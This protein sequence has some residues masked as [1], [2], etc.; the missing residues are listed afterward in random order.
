MT[1]GKIDIDGRSKLNT[2]IRELKGKN[3][4]SEVYLNKFEEMGYDS[5]FGL[6]YNY[7]N[8]GKYGSIRNYG[9]IS[10]LAI[11]P[12]DNFIVN[13]ANKGYV[14]IPFNDIFSGKSR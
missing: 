9:I 13:S 1:Q 8:N 4:I 3:I 2:M 11:I 12:P 10:K 7:G 6:I 14:T 5:L